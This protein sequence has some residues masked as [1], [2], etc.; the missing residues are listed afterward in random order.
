MIVEKRRERAQK[1]GIWL[2]DSVEEKSKAILF[3][4][5]FIYGSSEKRTRE[6][7]N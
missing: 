3:V 4:V 2:K 7:F 6:N 1:N 5:P